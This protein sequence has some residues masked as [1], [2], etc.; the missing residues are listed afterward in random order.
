M[1]VLYGWHHQLDAPL[2]SRS[3]LLYD[4]YEYTANNQAEI[5]ECLKDANFRSVEELLTALEKSEEQL[6]VLFG[7][8]QVVLVG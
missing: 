8:T 5:A 1:I 7:D 6:F 2:R 4:R 3:P